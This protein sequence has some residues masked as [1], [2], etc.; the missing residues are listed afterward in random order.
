[1]TGI[2]LCIHSNRVAQKVWHCFPCCGTEIVD[3]AQGSAW[4][5]AMMTAGGQAFFRRMCDSDHNSR[6]GA[7][8][9]LQQHNI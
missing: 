2:H 7:F 6:H 9:Y 3:F 5:T 8:R 4:A 1:M